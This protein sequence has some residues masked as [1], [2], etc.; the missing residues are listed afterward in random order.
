MSIAGILDGFA[1][2]HVAGKYNLDNSYS[3]ANFLEVQAICLDLHQTPVKALSTLAT[4]VDRFP[5]ITCWVCAPELE[6]E[7]VRTAFRL[8]AVEFFHAYTM[9]EEI[10]QALMRLQNRRP[11]YQIQPSKKDK[12]NSSIQTLLVSDGDSIRIK[13]IEGLL[14]QRKNL[15]FM[16]T[17]P[18]DEALERMRLMRPRLV[19]IDLAPEP[20]RCL[21]LIESTRDLLPSANVMVSYDHPDPVLVKK[22][23]N[24]GAADF[25]DPE[26]WKIDLP[27][28][29]ASMQ[30]EAKG[31]KT[32]WS[33][34]RKL[35][36]SS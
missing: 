31:D 28:A 24:L 29:L 34:V 18:V 21:P 1:D 23:Y 36:G 27:A 11:R 13:K 32:W 30:P 10:P 3:A 7:I 22:A 26:R 9:K 20:D 25:L 5:K 2:I 6:P 19:W 14:R 15:Y 33:L 35:L 16:A 12:R 4:L 8:G 17:V